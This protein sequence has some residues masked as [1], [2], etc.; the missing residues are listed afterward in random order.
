M[1]LRRF[2]PVGLVL[3]VTSCQQFNPTNVDNPNVT[4][5]A[6]LGSPDAARLWVRGTERTFLQALN[7][8]MENVEIVTDNYFN[9][10]TTQNKV[11]DIPRI[12]NQDLD[13]RSMFTAVARLREQ[14]TYGLETVLA[15]D[16]INRVRNEAELLWYRGMASIFVGETFTGM[17]ARALGPFVDGPGH[18]RLAIDDLRRARTLTTDA[19]L[20][21]ACTAALA[22]AYHRLG[23]R[24]NAVTEATALLAAAP[25]F[26]RTATFDGVNGPGNTFQALLTGASNNYQPLP[27]L[28]FLDPKYPNRGAQVQSAFPVLKA[29]EA[30]FILAE[31]ALATNDLAGARTRLQQALALV[32]SRPTELVD[33]RTQ[34]RGRAGGLV[35]YPDS[36]DYRV[37][38]SPG[39]PWQTGLVLWR[40][41]ATVRVPVIS[42]TSVTAARIEQLA[43][44]NDA[45][46]VLYLMRQ[47]VFLAEGRRSADLGIRFPV[48]LAEAQSNGNLSLTAP[49]MTAIVPA[50]L[51][52]NTG[53]DSFT[54]N[55][56]ARTVEIRHDVNAILVANRTSSLIMPFKN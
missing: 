55:A 10:F 15:A 32:Q 23:D 28:D 27:R 1:H 25:T 4:T 20:R 45:Y 7:S 11:F 26:L 3:C 48:P 13:V 16:T 12:D 17:P 29:E 2:L 40:R 14:A 47:E 18:L 33:S 38:V 52:G 39:A 43:A 35:I 41:T 30:H 56:T 36:A 50:F 31:S 21:N 54:L 6:Y 46:Y 19:A 8:L 24:P 5:P 37:A 9:N 44:I 51:P 49:Y 53:M 34:Q 42:G 22:R